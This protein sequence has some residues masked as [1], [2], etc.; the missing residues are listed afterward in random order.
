V[1]QVNVNDFKS[2]EDRNHFLESELDRIKKEYFEKK[3][4][5]KKD[6]I[7]QMANI[8][9][10]MGREPESISSEI[11]KLL[12]GE[13]SDRHV[14][15]VLSE[16]GMTRSQFNSNKYETEK[17]SRKMDMDNLNLVIMSPQE[18]KS[19]D[20]NSLRSL[21]EKIAQAQAL[22]HDEMKERKIPRLEDNPGSFLSNKSVTGV[23][24][25]DSQITKPRYSI[26]DKDRDY[27]DI[28]IRAFQELEHTARFMWEEFMPGLKIETEQEARNYAEAVMWMV[29]LFKPAKDEK[30]RLSLID[31]AKIISLYQIHGSS[32]ASKLFKKPIADLNEIDPSS[33]P[34]GFKNTM[35]ALKYDEKTGNIFYISPTK[36]HI[37]SKINFILERFTEFINRLKPVG[38]L[39]EMLDKEFRL[40]NFRA[41]VLSEKLSDSK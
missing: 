29:E 40:R 24:L 37:D 7:V 41:E 12:E 11:C 9:K 30:Y 39:M 25:H 5:L 34:E 22:V 26:T 4:S 13:V 27:Q 36:E 2:A 38:V 10:E 14:R 18:I 3:D 16:L 1:S 17:A 20:K 35:L 32:A 28:V 6:T 21:Q 8:L 31:W 33:L 15:R 23:P 19:L